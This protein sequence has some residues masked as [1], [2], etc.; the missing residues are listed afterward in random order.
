M[1]RRTLVALAI[2]V[3][4]VIALTGGV[5]LAQAPA[6]AGVPATTGTFDFSTVVFGSGWLGVLLW[7]SLFIDCF[8]G[9]WFVLD[10]AVSVRVSGTIPPA[11]VAKVAESMARGDVFK[12]LSHCEEEPG[13]LANVMTAG[14]SHVE[15][16]FEVIQEAIQLAADSECEQMMQKVSRLSVVAALAPMLGLLGTVQGMILGFARLAAADVAAISALAAAMSQALCATFAGLAVAI[17]AVVFFAFFRN[18][19]NR[20]ALRMETITMELIKDLRVVEV[21][22]E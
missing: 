10:C 12:A 1:R 8:V 7:G 2:V 20:I 6:S 22:K 15:E 11:L 9:V 17:P 5:V 19:A 13:P 14:F 3:V 21:V 16:C 18:R 4:F